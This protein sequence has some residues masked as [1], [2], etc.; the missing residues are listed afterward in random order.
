MLADGE[1]EA[2]TT[3]R[4]GSVRLVEALVDAA[5]LIRLDSDARVGDPELDPAIGR[6]SAR[7]D[8]PTRRAELDGVGQ[9][10]G[11]HLTDPPGVRLDR[12]LRLRRVG[13]ADLEGEPLGLR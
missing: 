4:A 5:E 11:Q 2:S 7:L 8:L 13:Q 9:H 12:D 1:P 10:V 3:S 6:I